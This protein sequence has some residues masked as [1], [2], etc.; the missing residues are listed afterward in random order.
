MV[1]IDCFS[2]L[3]F[4]VKLFYC[5]NYLKMAKINLLCLFL[6]ILNYWCTFLITD[7]YVYHFE[8]SVLIEK[9]FM[10]TI[11]SVTLNLSVTSNRSYKK[12]AVYNYNIKFYVKD[13][14]QYM[15][16]QQRSQ[17]I[18]LGIQYKVQGQEVNC[19]V[20]WNSVSW[21]FYQ[22]INFYAPWGGSM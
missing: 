10:G 7:H 16:H 19:K 12:Y 20:V 11:L 22:Y 17:T 2:L 3:V 13:K 4:N 15:Y 8:K 14:R 18:Q 5:F 1:W 6:W 9:A 21:Y